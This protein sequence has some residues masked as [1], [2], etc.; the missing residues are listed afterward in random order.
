[1]SYPLL[2][3]TAV[4]LLGGRACRHGRAATILRS[5]LAHVGEAGRRVRT[6]G[7]SER[8]TRQVAQPDVRRLEAVALVRRHAM[9]PG[10]ADDALGMAGVSIVQH[11]IH[12]HRDAL[13][14]EASHHASCRLE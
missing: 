10:C 14:I 4:P 6:L 9:L 3:S 13:P 5:P 1:M 8:R 12:G 7:Q 2:Q 11:G